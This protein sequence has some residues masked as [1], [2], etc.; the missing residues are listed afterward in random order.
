[1]ALGGSSTVCGA[2]AGGGATVSIFA[3]TALTDF[4]PSGPPRT[5]KQRKLQLSFKVMFSKSLVIL[6]MNVRK[7][8]WLE[9]Y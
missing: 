9:K 1:M 4:L 8:L 6:D 2:F 3:F 7:I 5:Y